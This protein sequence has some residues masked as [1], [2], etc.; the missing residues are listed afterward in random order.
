[1]SSFVPQPPGGAGNVAAPSTDQQQL[2]LKTHF[3]LCP[4][5]A[6]VSSLCVDWSGA[7]P[8]APG[9]KNHTHLTSAS[10]SQP[11]WSWKSAREIV[12]ATMLTV[13]I[14]SIRD[15]TCDLEVSSRNYTL[16]PLGENFSELTPCCRSF[17]LSP[18]LC[19]F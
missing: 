15:V 14:V 1:M 18:S 7:P 3:P 17:F 10:V 12:S 2:R 5:G 9:R 11:G 6:V 16:W 19:L 4:A 13:S 8:A